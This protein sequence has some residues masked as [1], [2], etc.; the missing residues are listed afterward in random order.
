MRLE[1]GGK[2]AII[3]GAGAGLAEP[4]RCDL[5]RKARM[6]WPST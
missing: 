4:A 5:P 2:V 1:K 6:Y 3:T